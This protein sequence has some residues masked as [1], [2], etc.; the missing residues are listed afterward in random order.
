VAQTVIG[1]GV[2]LSDIQGLVRWGY[3]HHTEAVVLLLQVKEAAAAR[4]WL[5]EL[6]PTSALPANP[7]PDTLLQVALTHDGMRAL[8]VRPDIIGGFSE[9]FLEGMAGDA[10]RTRRLG[11]IGASA[12][13]RWAWGTAERVA[14]VAVFLYAKQGALDLLQRGVEA[15]CASGFEVLY[16]LPTGRRDEQDN[17]EPFGFRD[18]LSQPELDWGRDIPV[19]DRDELTYRSRSC[20]GEFI[21]GFPNEYGLY[22]PRPQLDASEDPRASLPR[23]EEDASKVDI[24]RNGTYLV[25]RQLRQDVS[26]FWRALDERAGG[27]PAE[28]VRLGSLLVGRTPDGDPV[29]LDPPARPGAQAN[30]DFTFESDTQGHRCPIGAHIRRANPRNADLPPESTGLLSRLINILGFNAQARALDLAAST[31]FHRLLRR[32]RKYGAELTPEQALSLAQPP[33]SGLHFICLNANLQR[34]FEFVQSAWL[35]STQFNGLH[36]ESDPLLGN[37]V[38]QADGHRC[39]YFTM[40]Q[41]QSPAQ[42]LEGLP[43]FI[44]V[45]GGAYFFLPGIRALRFLV[46]D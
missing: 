17:S 16:R 22:T 45:V 40:P 10:N 43:Q 39:D 37:R 38:P 31:R 21:L 6:E 7:V 41:A 23:S 5:R 46:A 12:P 13:E 44:T 35:M 19:A 3:S 8:N 9:E 18:G 25:I 27:A 2:D 14:H 24:G 26:G 28:R 33:E 15:Q 36:E 32:G 20:L 11:D 30:S 4:R 29:V 34:Q 42:R 1:P